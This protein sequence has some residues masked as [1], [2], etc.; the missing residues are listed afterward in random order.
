MRFSNKSFSRISLYFFILIFFSSVAIAEEIQL[1]RPLT[2]GIWN[3]NPLCYEDFQGDAK[4]LFPAI[5]DYVALMENWDINYVYGTFREHFEALI[6][7]DL[8]IVLSV[9]VTEA[10]KKQMRFITED[11]FTNW[12]VVLIREGGSIS[13]LLD[14]A[15]KKIAAMDKAVYTDG[16]GGI[17]DLITTFALDT[18]IIPTKTY[19]E[20]MKLVE[21]GMADAAVV[22]RIVGDTQ[23]EKFGLVQSG[24][25]YLPVKTRIALN[26]DKPELAVVAKAIDRHMQ[27]LRTDQNS[28]YYQS[29]QKAHSGIGT[30]S[31]VKNTL[32]ALENERLSIEASKS[33]SRPDISLTT[34]EA[35]WLKE[36]PSF[37]VASFPLAPY[38]MK[39]RG[40]VEG[41][42]PGLVRM[43]S[44]KVNLTPQF[45]HYDLLS[46]ANKA[47]QT[48]VVAASLGRIKTPELEEYL[49]FSFETMPLNLAIFAQKTDDSIY[50]IEDL[51]AK[52]IASYTGYAL[53]P[54]LKKIFPDT[55]LVMADN[56]VGMM[57]LVAARNADAAIQEQYTG[58][59]MLRKNFI[60]VLEVK[61]FAQ[62]EGI[63]KMSGHSYVVHK[64]FALL[65]SILDKG[66]EALS[67]KERQSLWNK[68]FDKSS[69]LKEISEIK[70]TKKEDSWLKAHPI[71]KVGVDKD[72]APLEWLDE[73]GELQGVSR[74][75]LDALG[76]VFD[77]NYEWIVT[78]DQGRILQTTQK[79]KIDLFSALK[80][81]FIEDGNLTPISP[82][83]SLP[84]VA[85]AMADTP[86]VQDISYFENKTLAVIKKHSYVKE[87]T[88]KWPKIKL[89]QVQ[90]Q[91]EGINSIK[92]KKADA[93]LGALITTSNRL[94]K[95]GR[96]D[97]RVVGET[98]Y[99]LKFSM[100]PHSDN[101]ELASILKKF[102]KAIPKQKKEGIF[103]QWISVKYDHGLDAA[104]VWSIVLK[105]G[106]GAFV[107]VG[108]FVFWNRK[109]RLEVLK[110]KESEDR[111][112][113]LVGNIPGV[114]YRCRMDGSFNASYIS[115][116]VNNLAGFPA[117]AFLKDE[118][119][120]PIMEIIHPDDRTDL[121]Q[122]LFDST[123]KDR[124]YDLASRVLRKDNS[125]RHI[126]IRGRAIKN[127]YGEFSHLD[128]T[129]FDVTGKL[130]AENEL[131]ASERRVKRILETANEGFWFTDNE[132]VTIEVNPSMCAILDRYESQITDKKIFEFVDDGHLQDIRSLF[133]NN[134]TQGDLAIEV[135]LTRKDASFI[136]CLLNAT[137]FFDDKGNQAGIF[138]LVTDITAQK[139]I[140]AALEIE[141]DKAQQATRAKSDFL[142]N[143]S[144][145]IRTPMN[146]VLGMTHLAL[147]TELNKKQE[148]YLQKIKFS[149][150]SLLGVIN[151]ILD[152]SKIEAGKLEIESVKFNIMEMLGNLS[153]IV[154]IKADQ[155]GL[156]FLYK[157]DKAIP[158]NLIGDPLRLG[159][160]L[161]NLANNA[162]KFTENGEIVISVSIDSM[163]E[164]DIKLY[165]IV[166][167]TG[168]GMSEEQ[169]SKLFRAF[170]QADTSTTRKYGG[171]GLGLSI[172]K[173]LVEIMDGHIWVESTPGKGSR[174]QFTVTC[175]LQKG[176]VQGIT[177]NTDLLKGK[178]TLVVDDS[179]N[180]REIF[181]NDLDSMGIN[182]HE[183]SGGGQALEM[184]SRAIEA[185]R[186]YELVLTDWRMPDINGIDV[187]RRIKTEIPE[188]SRPD[189]ILI[190]AFGREE[191]ME[192][193]KEV[194]LD[195][196]LIKPVSPSVLFNTIV[197][198]LELSELKTFKAETLSNQN[199]T[200]NLEGNSILLV[201]DNE[202]NQDVA[203]EILEAAGV[204]VDIAENGA[205][206]VEK[207]GQT[208]Y[209]AV[210]MDVQM[211]VMDGH[212]ATRAI[213]KQEQFKDL[214]I[215]AMTAGAMVGDKERS[216][217]A[218]MNDYISK[219]IDHEQLF[220]TLS[221]YV[222]P[223]KQQSPD[224][225]KASAQN[226]S[227]GSIDNRDEAPLVEIPG[228]DI[229]EGI[230]RFL[231]NRES[232]YR[233]LG[234][235]RISQANAGSDIRNALEQKDFELAKRLAHTAKGVCANA[236]AINMQ[237][238]SLNL[239]NAIREGEQDK[240]TEELA[241]F[242]K[243]LGDMIQSLEAFEELLPSEKKVNTIAKTEEMDVEAFRKPLKKLCKLLSEDDLD[244]E[245]VLGELFQMPGAG[246]INEELSRVNASIG[247]YDFAAA[248]E[249]VEA[250]M[251]ERGIE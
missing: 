102:F 65:K 85:F 251:E 126:R 216:L 201:E 225:G 81:N 214:P 241:N 226:T 147:Q 130:I 122:K 106:A 52:R 70:L 7:G 232:Y 149:A 18:R 17:R 231:G 32:Q 63:K 88:R 244:A 51:E 50:R 30:T 61:G 161:L 104:Y 41:Y 99:S 164:K 218:G 190:T 105:V 112:K 59:H 206:A 121:K 209:D 202:L 87:I 144:H 150:N 5:L 191:I 24:I 177:F 117:S 165:F 133:D 233:F 12:G 83:I 163:T 169:V 228:F 247:N 26:K 188:K 239:E 162:I 47:V 210:L 203:K 53:N 176:A 10:R 77:L 194:G 137:R 219:P 220:E 175:L 223:G 58:L 29:L 64:D 35:Q 236:S 39:D 243:S 138:A 124:P 141:K 237:Q 217:E 89:L 28:M 132:G 20:A 179:R 15:G 212:Q 84:V 125:I 156:E 129:I 222:K 152:F 109:L 159:Q 208:A 227:E 230:S 69:V 42:M 187:A 120:K 72:L 49:Q 101:P 9:S 33:L 13:N 198:T 37:K 170:T 178:K 38:I 48:G 143:M 93:F 78:S 40:R 184:I 145:E 180:A 79:E 140:Q 128:G 95:M 248:L 114:V 75:F 207:V 116:E 4:G 136:P 246:T 91:E 36:H 107:L 25:V 90:S 158:T 1:K 97:I 23:S 127:K 221:R 229:R 34:E 224:T 200:Y 235:V 167:D 19:Q 8:D 195:A 183:A 27:R 153:N 60:T 199:Q 110:R 173:H 174:F 43:I 172:S 11:I 92:T 192:E 118:P 2:I 234:K 186:P 205:V 71:L 67:E 82:H 96:V 238:A 185:G 151:D 155:K 55:Q 76:Q 3:N 22:N 123:N 204:I 196:F 31:L 45:I 242:E 44:A 46:D 57:Q 166:E 115:E 73:K 213:R 54:L 245:D 197:E 86:Y 94:A 181:L 135:N 16:K 182:A 171:T 160:I 142:A 240:Y 193:A 62:F 56:A 215:I 211:P 6:R 74:G 103:R 154:G 250:V 80:I 108:I 157:V 249:Q 134:D 66:Y 68:W 98:D 148:S 119:V 139:E 21:D 100:A 146:A 131:K 14:L 189:I 111:F 113:T 168:I